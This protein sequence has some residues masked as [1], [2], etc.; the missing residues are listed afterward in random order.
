M[1]SVAATNLHIPIGKEEKNYFPSKET[2]AQICLHRYT[3]YIYLYALLIGMC[4][5]VD[6]SI[7]LSSINPLS[8]YLSTHPSPKT[9]TLHQLQGLEFRVL[10]FRVLGF[11]VLGF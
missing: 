8:I 2:N 4:I 9:S 5:S 10:G 1:Y 7:D 6:S 11:R 3:W